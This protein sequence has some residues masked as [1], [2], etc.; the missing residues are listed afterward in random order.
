MSD[1][2]TSSSGADQT[3]PVP[4]D[5]TAPVAPV[6]P[7]GPQFDAL[8][9]DARKELYIDLSIRNAWDLLRKLSYTLPYNGFK[10]AAQSAEAK[11]KKMLL[12][13]PTKKVLFSMP[14]SIML[15]NGARAA[16]DT[17]SSFKKGGDGGGIKENLFRGASLLGGIGLA[18]GTGYLLGMHVWNALTTN[19][20]GWLS[21]VD[22]L[23]QT[24]GP[25]FAAKA[26]AA[27][28]YAL[29]GASGLAIVTPVY[30]AASLAVS[31]VIGVVDSAISSIAAV[32]NLPRAYTRFK[33]AKQGIQ[34]TPETKRKLEREFEKD[35]LDSRYEYGLYRE[36]QS[37]VHSLSSD[38]K[39]KIYLDL[40]KQF[41]DSVASDDNTPD[42]ELGTTGPG[43]GRR[44]GGLHFS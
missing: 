26:S 42:N 28:D 22:G 35:S 12:D 1:N 34:Y 24:G 31:T 44:P 29:A 36:A 19:T 17:A 4:P 13:G 10:H 30:T 39:Q 7:Q 8:E 16:Y 40:K 2:E 41:G 11:A 14:L 6:A 23:L 38:S 9:I 20:P 27:I 33:D 25:T 18:A 3:V 37:V 43:N 5:A 21:T 15:R 32:A